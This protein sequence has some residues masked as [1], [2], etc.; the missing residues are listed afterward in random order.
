M[1]TAE[2]WLLIPFKSPTW[3]QGIGGSSLPVR[4]GQKAVRRCALLGR[5]RPGVRSRR[6]LG[7]NLGFR[8]LGHRLVS[9]CWGFVIRLY[10]DTD[11]ALG[12]GTAQSL[13]GRNSVGIFMI[14]AVVPELARDDGVACG[15]R[16]RCFRS[17][18]R[19]WIGKSGG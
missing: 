1:N 16:P 10:D 14:Y 6:F 7:V 3:P 13:F 15:V 9:V 18:G 19:M 4:A 2:W 17:A 8:V 12:F 11:G 5:G